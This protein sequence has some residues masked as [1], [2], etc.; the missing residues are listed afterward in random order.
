MPLK[1][2]HPHSSL[3]FSPNPDSLIPTLSLLLIITFAAKAVSSAKK[4]STPSSSPS[5]ARGSNLFDSYS[6]YYDKPPPP[7]S[8]LKRLLGGGKSSPPSPDPS[9]PS[10]EYITVTKLNSL[11][12]SYSYSLTSATTSQPNARMQFRKSKA[13]DIV[14]KAIG[15]GGGHL[16]ND[17]RED[18]LAAE[19]ELLEGGKV[20]RRKME[21]LRKELGEVIGEDIQD[22]IGEYDAG[23]GVGKGE[24]KGGKDDVVS[25]KDKKG[26]GGDV[27]EPMMNMLKGG[28][29]DN[30]F[31]EIG[32]TEA[33]IAAIETE[34]IRSVSNTVAHSIAQGKVVGT[35]EA[36]KAR[37]L[38]VELRMRGKEQGWG[39][40]LSEME[41]RPLATILG[42]EQDS[43]EVSLSPKRLFVL[44]F[45]GD[46]TASQV[47]SLREEISAV[48]LHSNPY[49]EVLVVLQSGGGTVTG[50]GLA[51][52][53]LE[54]IKKAGCKLTIAVEQVAASGG[55]MMACT[56]DVIVASPFAVL[57][58]IGVISDQPN[59][60]E[61]L[62][63]E[64]VEFSTVTAGKY[65]RTLT[66]T[67]K[68]T[69]EDFEKVS[70][71]YGS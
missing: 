10:T 21:G 18:L 42:S 69:K 2:N 31:K 4:D 9:I 26:E 36:A 19:V 59:F 56:G 32:K 25:G 30:I 20:L 1:T 33:K 14:V 70:E 68:P 71:W 34:F 45:P 6:S 66:P 50:Y 11:Y 40:I 27:L 55:Y 23:E 49:D 41:E 54:R 35:E 7:T 60:Y 37:G 17:A 8:P 24:G 62:K 43:S 44:N 61:R 64:G 48:T 53:Q 51:A 52:A 38:A 58:S 12:D 67:K 57:G 47:S 3:R 46:V 5:D 65:K 39:G 29:E 22:W 15:E 63:R 28:R 16:N 13:G